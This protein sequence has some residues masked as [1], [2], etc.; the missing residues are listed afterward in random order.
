MELLLVKIA[1]ALVLPPGSIL[2]LG[3]LGFALMRRWR[4]AGAAVVGASLV[5]L[6]L[7][8]APATGRA[9]LHS[10]EVHPPLDPATLAR[11]SPDAIVV[12]GGGRD[13][14]APEYAAGETVSRASLA[15][16]RYAARLYFETGL[17]VLV[18]G[19]RVFGGGRSEAALMREALRDFD[20]AVR[21]V[22]D[23]S[24][25][26]AENARLSAALLAEHGAEE[27]VLVTDAW[28]MA[29]SVSAFEGAGV[30]VIPAP[31]GFHLGSGDTPLALRLLPSADGLGMSA[32]ALHEYAGRLWYAIRY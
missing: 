30:S 31:T 7:L 18:T 1:T 10:L 19:G 29:R 13:R 20:V 2:I 28:H 9:L 16:L 14:P 23:R 15:R 25:N 17:P 26:T 3:I 32:Q 5:L 11:R 24:R 21:W 12:L 6:W 27:I 4:M 8:S 22:E